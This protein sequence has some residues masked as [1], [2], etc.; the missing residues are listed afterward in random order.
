MAIRSWPVFTS[1]SRTEGVTREEELLSTITI[2]EASP[3][4]LNESVAGETGAK[5]TSESPSA[6]LTGMIGKSRT[7][8][9]ARPR[10]NA[11]RFIA[12]S[13]CIRGI[14]TSTKR[15]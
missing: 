4:S 5:I 2:R 8:V 7:T 10:S 6:A 1:T 12:A 11:E 9:E 14:A 13:S 3:E 15:H